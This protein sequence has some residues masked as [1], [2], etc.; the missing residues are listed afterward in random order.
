MLGWLFIEEDGNSG[1][2]YDLFCN[3]NSGEVQLSLTFC[4]GYSD[5]VTDCGIDET[6]KSLPLILASEFPQKTI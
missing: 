3:V 4:L 5:L 2:P 6:S 1:N